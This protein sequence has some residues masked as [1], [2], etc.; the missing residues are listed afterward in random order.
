MQKVIILQARTNSSRLHGRVTLPLAGKP[1]IWHVIERLKCAKMIDRIC[2]ATTSD[3]SD[4]AL[5]EYCRG[6]KVDVVRGSVNDVL[7][8]FIQ[9]AFTTQADLIVRVAGDNPL[10]HPACIDAEIEYINNCSNCDYVSMMS[11]PFGCSSETFTLRTLEKLDYVSRDQIHRKHVTYY[12]HDK[13]GSHGF[14]M[15]DLPTPEYIARPEIRLTVDTQEDYELLSRIYDE[16]Y[17]EGKIIDLASVIDFLDN[18][19][20]LL[21]I[22]KGI[23]QIPSRLLPEQ[24][25]T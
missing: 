4:D 2:V 11:L 3:S 9:A 24:V 1:I 6:C 22:N 7:A 10:I 17:C 13:V 19:P 16:L 12:L 15:T 20:D 5:A 14:H 18:N 21:N 23:V 8:R 25:L